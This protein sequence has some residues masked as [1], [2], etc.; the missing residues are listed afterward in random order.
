MKDGCCSITLGKVDVLTIHNGRC[1]ARPWNDVITLLKVRISFGKWLEIVNAISPSPTNI[2]FASCF[3]L[4]AERRNVGRNP[5]QPGR[6]KKREIPLVRRWR[7]FYQLHPIN[8]QW[9]AIWAELKRLFNN[10]AIHKK[11]I[12]RWVQLNVISTYLSKAKF[13]YQKFFSVFFFR[14]RMG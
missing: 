5:P 12:K 8:P 6:K 7:G 2:R 10:C 9:A 4:M 14:Y 3:W 11:V 13:F 1:Y